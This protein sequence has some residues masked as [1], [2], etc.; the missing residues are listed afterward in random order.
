MPSPRVEPESESPTEHSRQDLDETP[1]S[2]EILD[3]DGQETAPSNSGTEDEVAVTPPESVSKEQGSSRVLVIALGALVVV[4]VI[5]VVAVF[6]ARSSDSSTTSAPPPTT[7]GSTP[8]AS[9]SAAEGP[10]SELVSY[11]AETTSLISNFRAQVKALKTGFKTCTSRATND[12]TTYKPCVE[13]IALQPLKTL[14]T[15]TRPKPSDSGAYAECSSASSQAS[16]ALEKAVTARLNYFHALKV[17]SLQPPSDPEDYRTKERTML[18]AERQ[19]HVTTSAFEIACQG[20][21]A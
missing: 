12:Y 9:S 11:V 7:A 14:T 16:L 3:D 6:A 4:V 17:L 10:S 19:L 1:S 5:G 20:A 15:D 21:T 8:A 2:D 13:A 18:K